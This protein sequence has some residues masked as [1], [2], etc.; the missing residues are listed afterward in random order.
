MRTL[1]FKS[2]SLKLRIQDAILVLLPFSLAMIGM[3]L[4]G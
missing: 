1:D 3:L 2:Y 4:L